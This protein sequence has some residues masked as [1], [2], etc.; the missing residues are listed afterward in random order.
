[1][2]QTF[3]TMSHL[4][5]YEE[6]T[7]LQCLGFKFA[8]N[9]SSV[10]TLRVDITIVLETRCPHNGRVGGGGGGDLRL[11]LALKEV[12]RFV[13]T[14]CFCKSSKVKCTEHVATLLVC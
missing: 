10:K 9:G 12:L 8:G 11:R 2:H 1:M 13:P 4:S 3:V 5:A 7:F 6:L 14:C